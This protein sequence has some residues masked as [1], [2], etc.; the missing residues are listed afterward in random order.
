[1]DAIEFRISASLQGKLD[2][3]FPP[4]TEHFPCLS[5][6]GQELWTY[7][8]QSTIRYPHGKLESQSA[9][10]SGSCGIMHNLRIW[11]PDFRNAMWSGIGGIFFPGSSDLRHLLS[12]IRGGD[13]M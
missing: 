2:V 12:R 9:K 10:S 4:Q 7:Y 6:D 1:M 5:N 13:Q 11:T 8:I 3:I